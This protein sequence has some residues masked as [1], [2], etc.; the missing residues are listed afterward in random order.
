MPR[1]S[2]FQNPQK[3]VINTLEDQHKY[4]LPVF[5]RM[6][7]N[8][9]P[10]DQMVRPYV[11]TQASRLG[12]LLGVSS[13]LMNK[14]LEGKSA[15]EQDQEATKGAKA[16]L[17]GQTSDVTSNAFYKGYMK[18]QGVLASQADAAQLE[19]DWLATPKTG[20]SFDQWSSEW[21]AAKADGITD[22]AF[23]DGYQPQMTKAVLEARHKEATKNTLEFQQKVDTDAKD[24]IRTSIGGEATFDMSTWEKIRQLPAAQ[25]GNK[26]A[27]ELLYQTVKDAAQRGDFEYVEKVVPLFS[28]RHLDSTPGLKLYEPE[29]ENLKLEAHRRYSQMTKAEKDAT[30][31]KLKQ[32][33]DEKF[34]EGF[35]DVLAGDMKLDDFLAGVDKYFQGHPQMGIDAMAEL[36]GIILRAGTREETREMKSNFNELLMGIHEGKA[37]KAD[38]L[39]AE[40]E[41]LITAKQVSELIREKSAID[42][43]NRQE[44]AQG[45]ALKRQE[46]SEIK[47]VIGSSIMNSIP[48]ED[49]LM[50]EGPE[51]VAYRNEAQILKLAAYKELDSIIGKSDVDQLAFVEKYQKRGKELYERFT[52][53]GNEKWKTYKPVFQDFDAWNQAFKK[54]PND[55]KVIE[56][57]KYRQWLQT[58]Q[59]GGK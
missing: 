47:S 39:K 56:D 27:N 19:K 37:G 43:R 38:F 46:R 31:V 29:T 21:Y 30:K 55:P 50:L 2:T 32:E 59:S 41:G 48:T 51:K 53:Q 4:D 20:I 34:S 17:E 8:A 45:Q 10:V 58:N 44:A 35:A 9:A 26:S 18:M 11:S 22:P 33:F 23:L 54:N 49:A 24:F 16:S 52:K 36:R 5:R 57:A 3:Q 28:Q 13:P 15:E 42:S 7:I 25:V 1:T 12:D 6:E 14:Y 40:H